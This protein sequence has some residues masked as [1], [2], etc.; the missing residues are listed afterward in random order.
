MPLVAGAAA[1]LYSVNPTLSAEDARSA[2][3]DGAAEMSV[4]DGYIEYKRFLD[5][6][7]ALDEL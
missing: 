1:L 6:R 5:V 3:E 4:L 2:L 7:G